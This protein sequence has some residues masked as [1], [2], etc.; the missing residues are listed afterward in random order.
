MCVPGL[1]A[2]VKWNLSSWKVDG[3]IYSIAGTFEK[4]QAVS[5]KRC[6]RIAAIPR[7]LGAYVYC[8]QS[9]ATLQVDKQ[10]RWVL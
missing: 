5:R 10:A 4:E 6:G 9:P 8:A 2:I 3:A 1:G 7:G